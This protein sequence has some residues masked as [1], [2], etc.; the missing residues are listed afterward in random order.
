M[1]I[2]TT[3]YTMNVPLSYVSYVGAFSGSSAGRRLTETFLKTEPFS[4]VVDWNRMNPHYHKKSF[5]ARKA[6][7]GAASVKKAQ[8]IKADIRIKESAKKEEGKIV[9]VHPDAT[10]PVVVIT[11]VTAPLTSSMDSATYYTQLTTALNQSISSQ[12]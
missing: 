8:P 11:K 3:A 1:I 4:N 9:S 2:N 12:Q 7:F 6:L 10:S 5:A